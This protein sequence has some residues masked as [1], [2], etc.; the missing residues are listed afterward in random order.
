MVILFKAATPISVSKQ[1]LAE[2]YDLTPAEAALMAALLAGRSLAE[3]AET[4]EIS[5]NTAKTHLRHIFF[6]KTGHRRQ[7]DL[8][9]AILANR[10]FAAAQRARS[11]RL[12]GGTTKR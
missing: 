10:I 11:Q 1:L 7:I 6:E 12:L 5:P 2:T 3:Y 9:R 8:V 4:A